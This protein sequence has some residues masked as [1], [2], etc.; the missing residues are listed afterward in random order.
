M[1]ASVQYVVRDVVPGTLMEA[2]I[3]ANGVPVVQ[4]LGVRGALGTRVR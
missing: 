1:R 3:G 2:E 4:S